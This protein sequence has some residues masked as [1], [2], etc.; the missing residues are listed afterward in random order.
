MLETIPAGRKFLSFYKR[1]QETER[2]DTEVYSSN[3]KLDC[4]ISIVLV[5]VGNQLGNY[6]CFVIIPYGIKIARVV[7]RKFTHVKL[8]PLTYKRG[9]VLLF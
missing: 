4:H 9:R 7:L 2:E 8:D 1:R 6:S 3:N 5:T